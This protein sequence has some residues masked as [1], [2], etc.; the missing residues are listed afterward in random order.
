[1]PEFRSLGLED[2]LEL[3]SRR[4]D[5]PLLAEATVFGEAT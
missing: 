2:V 1:M 3:T 5:A 4:Y